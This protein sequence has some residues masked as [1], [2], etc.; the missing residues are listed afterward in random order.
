LLFA[1]DDLAV[2]SFTVNG[3]QKGTDKVVKYCRDLN[4]RCD[5]KKDKILVFLRKQRN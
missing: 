1:A 3:Q 4:L 5:L 2:G